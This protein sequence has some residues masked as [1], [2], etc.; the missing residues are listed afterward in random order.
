MQVA[1]V[2]NYVDNNTAKYLAVSQINS[3]FD[4]A[5]GTRHTAHGTRHTAHGTQ[6]KL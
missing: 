4:T 3:I 6:T 1:A 2:N 5:H